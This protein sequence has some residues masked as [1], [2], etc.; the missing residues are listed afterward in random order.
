MQDKIAKQYQCQWLL[1]K[2]VPSQSVA[3]SIVVEEEMLVSET[4]CHNPGQSDI[5][6][7]KKRCSY[8]DIEK[9][10]TAVQEEKFSL[11]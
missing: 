6:N 1:I 7:A 5:S 11:E 8:K 3:N 9:K 2:S 4:S 10:V